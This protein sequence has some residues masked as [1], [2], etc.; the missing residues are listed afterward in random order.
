MR[1]S[2]L[3]SRLKWSAASKLIY[4]I[5][6][7][8]GKWRILTKYTEFFVCLLLFRWFHRTLEERTRLLA[9]PRT[10]YI[11]FFTPHRWPSRRNTVDPLE[12]QTL[13][14]SWHFF[15]VKK[16]N[17]FFTF[18]FSPPFRTLTLGGVSQNFSRQTF[19]VPRSC[20]HACCDS[21]PHFITNRRYVLQ[22]LYPNSYYV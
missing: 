20:T 1:P 11:V 3:G 10:M 6:F 14:T 15:C 13:G 21:P 7:G 16:L 22:Q 9:R 8:L 4:K 17:F 12:F 19:C 2:E 5:C 18:F